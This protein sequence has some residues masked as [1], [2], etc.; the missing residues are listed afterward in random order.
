MALEGHCLRHRPAAASE[1]QAELRGGTLRKSKAHAKDRHPWRSLSCSL[2]AFACRL[3]AALASTP[4]RA[5]PSLL[6][7][8]SA[9]QR[10]SGTAGLAGAG[11]R[12]GRASEA[13]KE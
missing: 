1:G 9:D 5:R 2:Q 13:E 7:F 8:A 10:Y 12:P 6:G 11:A 4:P 3:I